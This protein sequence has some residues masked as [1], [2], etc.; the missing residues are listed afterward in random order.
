MKWTIHQ[1]NGKPKN[2]QIPINVQSFTTEPGKTNNTNR[3]IISDKFESIVKEDKTK[4][5]QQTKV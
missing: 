5:L 2:G 4:P 3:S 1:H